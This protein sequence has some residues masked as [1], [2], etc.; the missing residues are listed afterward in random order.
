VSSPG[1]QHKQTFTTAQGF[2]FDDAGERVPVTMPEDPAHEGQCCE[3]DA[4]RIRRETL[5][6]Y[7]S[8]LLQSGDAQL[9]GRKVLIVGY[10]LKCAGAPLTLEELGARMGVTKGRACQIVSELNSEKGD[11]ISVIS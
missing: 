2:G 1:I 8:V 11:F 6:R 3:E 7:Q 4:A 9:I 10:L 5:M